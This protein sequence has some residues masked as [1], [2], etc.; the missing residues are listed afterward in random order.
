MIPPTEQVNEHDH[1]ND[2]HENNHAHELFE[3]AIAQDCSG[4]GLELKVRDPPPPSFLVVLKSSVTFSIY[5]LVISGP[6]ILG[7]CL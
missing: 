7:L 6:I 5:S 3:L 4:A 1:E 2:H